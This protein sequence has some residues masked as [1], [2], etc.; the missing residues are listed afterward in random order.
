MLISVVEEL[1]LLIF[2]LIPQS[3]AIT[4]YRNKRLSGLTY[5]NYEWILI[6]TKKME[7]E[8]NMSGMQFALI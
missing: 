5:N 6:N 8:K 3:S 1:L 2:L 7:N 4:L